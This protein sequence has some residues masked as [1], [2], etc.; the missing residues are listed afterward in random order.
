LIR[1]RPFQIS[2]RQK[3][4]LYFSFALTVGSGV[5]WAVIWHFFREEIDMAAPGENTLLKVHLAGAM[6]LLVVVGAALPQHA[7]KS[8]AARTNRVASALFLS[9][10]LGSVVTGYTILAFV[11]DTRIMHFTHIGL[12]IAVTL[13]LPLHILVGKF[14]WKKRLADRQRGE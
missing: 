12:G 2:L 4:W 1:R 8:W 14:L 11:W 13:L 7:A 3:A 9:A 10:L 5:T 6:I